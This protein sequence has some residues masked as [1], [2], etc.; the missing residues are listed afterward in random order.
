[1]KVTLLQQD[2]IA[3]L[4]SV[5]RSVG[6]KSS[7]PVLANILIRTE[8]GNLKLSATNLEVGVI[9]TV[10]AQVIEE[11]EITVPARTLLEIVSSLTSA[12]LTFETSSDQLKISTDNFNAILNGISA[13]EFPTIPIVSE[14][15]V[16]I[17]GQI[18]KSTIPQITFAA[19][20]DEGR[21]ILTG[22]LTE[23]KKDS[24]ELVATDGF[25]LAHK[26]AKIEGDA[27]KNLR[28]LI[29]RR[30]FEEVVRLIAEEIGEEQKEKV[31]ISMA[32]SQ[33]Q[34]IFKIGQTL[35]STR[36]IEGQFPA[37]EKIIP[38]KFEN[39]TI[40]DRTE[41]LK[42]VKLASVFAKGDANIVK[43][44]TSD[45]KLKLTSEAKELGGQENEVEAQTEGVELVVAFNSKFLIDALSACQSSQI[46]IE[47]S[48]S[49]SPALIKPLGEEGLEYVVM[50]IR[51]N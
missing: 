10:K 29:P 5:S 46:R 40:I 42:A 15:T 25:R 48:G 35:V 23:I 3:P 24:L 34:M 44:A 20:S 37:W 22:I 36:L 38:T 30:T 17:E 31:E 51:L 11:G 19:A 39:R 45:G 43:I 47:F 4:Q 33:N 32:D 14:N 13:S 41:L 26:T 12:K 8:D 27:D 18:L 6:V 2:L 50:P 28:C 9:K 7:L 16:H 21:P 49:L 1:M